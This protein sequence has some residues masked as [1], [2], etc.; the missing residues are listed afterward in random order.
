M[1]QEKRGFSLSGYLVFVVLIA[2]HLVFFAMMATTSQ[3]G[4][5]HV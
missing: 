2:L 5:A 1:V 3:I 4:R